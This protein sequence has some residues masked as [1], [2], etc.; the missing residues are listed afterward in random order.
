MST[1]PLS[2]RRTR[3]NRSSK[4]SI[5]TLSSAVSASFMQR[6]RCRLKI[7]DLVLPA[8]SAAKLKRAPGLSYSILRKA[9]LASRVL[10]R[11][12]QQR[13]TPWRQRRN[14][15]LSMKSHASNSLNVLPTANVPPEGRTG[16]QSHGSEPEGD[17]GLP[18]HG[19]QPYKGLLRRVVRSPSRGAAA[20]ATGLHQPPATCFLADVGRTS[21]R[22]AAAA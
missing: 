13:P 3:S 14:G 20:R 4:A 18:A 7:A 5:T 22:I 12:H 15:R 1:V 17:N 9:A 19:E 2:M 8:S 21:K 11:R 10:A 16:A 6:S